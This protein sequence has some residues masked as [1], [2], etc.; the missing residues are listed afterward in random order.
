MSF[1]AL[2]EQIARTISTTYGVPYADVLK[3]CQRVE[4]SSVGISTED[5]SPIHTIAA[6]SS[7][8]SKKAHGTKGKASEKGAQEVCKHVFQ[9]GKNKDERCTRP[10]RDGSD[11]CPSHCGTSSGEEPKDQVFQPEG[12]VGKNKGKGKNKI[13]NKKP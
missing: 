11:R 3:A 2:Y 10:V 8:V 13:P 9:R 5:A 1:S 12:A 4:K 7:V 6:S